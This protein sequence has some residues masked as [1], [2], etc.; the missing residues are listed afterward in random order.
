VRAQAQDKW[1][2]R[3][4]LAAWRIRKCWIY[5]RCSAARNAPAWYVCAVVVAGAFGARPML[6][7]GCGGLR[8]L[9]G[10]KIDGAVHASIDMAPVNRR[11]MLAMPLTWRIASCG[12]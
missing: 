5:P 11:A 3:N 9:S 7:V 8:G 12:W 10:P 4:P 2:L 6:Y 1:V